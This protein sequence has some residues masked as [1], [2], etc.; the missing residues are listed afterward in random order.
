MGE[1]N[2]CSVVAKVLVW[3]DL[4]FFLAHQPLWVISYQI[5]FIHIYYIY[6]ICKH[7]LLITLLNEPKLIYLHTVK[8]FQVLLCITNNSIKHQSFVYTQ[9]IDQ[10]VQFQTIKLSISHSFVFCLN[11]K[12]FYLTHRWNPN[13][14]G[15]SGLGSNINEGVLYIPQSSSIVGSSPSKCLGHSPGSLTPWVK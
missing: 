13:N 1:G 2:P 4:F 11:V 5:L 12:Q 7:I 8:W 9:L 14:T 3:F 6:K 10:T 15:Q